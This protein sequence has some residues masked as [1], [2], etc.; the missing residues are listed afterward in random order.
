V[1][2]AAGCDSGEEGVTPVNGRR[3]KLLR[4][5]GKRLGWSNGTGGACDGEFNGGGHGGA[6][7]RAGTAVGVAHARGG[8]ATLK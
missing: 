6:V 2:A 7:E 4:V 1:A 5:L 8:H 3:H